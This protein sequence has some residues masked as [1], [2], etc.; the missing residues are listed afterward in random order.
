[1]SCIACTWI[2]EYEV[3]LARPV[4][5][6]RGCT[7]LWGLK[8]PLSSFKVA[9]TLLLSCGSADSLCYAILLSLCA[10]RG[11]DRMLYIWNGYSYGIR[12]YLVTTIFVG[13]ALTSL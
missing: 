6:V 3:G 9:V 4:L 11:R 13:V 8:R 10:D 5:L 12:V 1:M 7:D 2:N